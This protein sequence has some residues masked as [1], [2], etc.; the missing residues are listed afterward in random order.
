MFYIGGTSTVYVLNAEWMQLDLE[1][2]EYIFLMG[3]KLS[4]EGSQAL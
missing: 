3:V 4:G 2:L 1:V